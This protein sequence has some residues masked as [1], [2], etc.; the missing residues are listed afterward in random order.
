MFDT[1]PFDEWG[2]T[3]TQFWTFAGEEG[4]STG[5]WIIVALGFVVMIV[6]FFWFVILENGK[7]A[8]Q[9][10]RLRATGALDRPPETSTTG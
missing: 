8:R 3:I 5:T 7:L 9:A 10:E 2:D 4:T 1:W 6:A